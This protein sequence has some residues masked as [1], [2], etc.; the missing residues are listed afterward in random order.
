MQDIITGMTS[1]DEF[2]LDVL[3]LI[4]TFS[5]IS[6]N[7]PPI[8]QVPNDVLYILFRLVWTLRGASFAGNSQASAGAHARLRLMACHRHPYSPPLDVRSHV[9]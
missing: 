6:F 5:K 8:Y 1:T 7:E 3:D 2:N 9:P 4:T